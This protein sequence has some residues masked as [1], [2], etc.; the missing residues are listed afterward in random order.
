MH[1]RSLFVMCVLNNLHTAQCTRLVLIN[2][3]Q[4][5]NLVDD[6]MFSAIAKLLRLLPFHSASGNYYI[7]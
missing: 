7:C 6:Y 3:Y 4:I 5:D 2:F 1:L